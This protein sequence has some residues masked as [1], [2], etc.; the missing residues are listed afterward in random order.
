MLFCNLLY[1]IKQQS[2]STSHS[3][4]NNELRVLACLYHVGSL[5]WCCIWHEYFHLPHLTPLQTLLVLKLHLLEGD[6]ELLMFL[7]NSLLHVYSDSS[8]CRIWSQF[9]F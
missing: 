9:F 4:R 6:Q 8:L 3:P 2:M 5:L 7:S 1:F